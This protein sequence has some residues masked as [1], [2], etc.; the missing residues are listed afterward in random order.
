MLFRHRFHGPIARGEVTLTVR[1]WARPQ[2][3]AGGRYRVGGTMI[4]VTG[5]SRVPLAA[6]TAEHARR[7]GFA[8]LDDLLEEL[9]RGAGA[10]GEPHAWLVEFRAVGPYAAPPPRTVTAE[11]LADVSRRLDALDRLRGRRWTRQALALIAERPAT[12]ARTLAA[13]M[14]METLPFKAD[15]RKL[16]ALG[17]TR[18]LEVGY[19]LTDLGRAVL[20]GKSGGSPA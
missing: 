7:A 3:K 1:G 16:K 15:V 11:A 6:L 14:A 13:E 20:E 17:L 4:E 19:E 18:S 8:T 2:A 9:G 12:A 5:L 10:G